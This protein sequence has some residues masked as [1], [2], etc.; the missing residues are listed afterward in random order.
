MRI[1]LVIQR[2]VGQRFYRRCLRPECVMNTTIERVPQLTAHEVNDRLRSQAESRV[3]YYAHHPEAIDQRLRELDAEWDV[4][5]TI[6]T[7][8][9]CTVLTGFFLGAVLG[10]K[11]LALTA[12]AS[13]MVLLHA[14]HGAYPLLPLLRRAGLRTAREISTERYAIKA[15]RGDF[16]PVRGGLKG[17]EHKAF[18]AARH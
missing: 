7:E 4:E 14:L 10:R 1:G 3:A 15:L 11:W 18:E 16:L 17:S 5:R 12:V 13:G 6:E 9:A 2:G 8:A